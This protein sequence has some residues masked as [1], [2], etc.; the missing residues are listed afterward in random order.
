[1]KDLGYING[2]SPEIARFLHADMEDHPSQSEEWKKLENKLW[3]QVRL[4]PNQRDLYYQET[5]DGG[6]RL[7]PD[8]DYPTEVRKPHDF[9][10][11]ET[12]TREKGI[13]VEEAQELL[14]P[15]PE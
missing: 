4:R 9:T 3:Q 7:L 5:D 6:W 15:P 12:V 8:L 10:P 11:D 13:S 2:D 1:M 14:K